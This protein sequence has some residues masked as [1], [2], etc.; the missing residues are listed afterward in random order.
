MAYKFYLPLWFGAYF[1]DLTCHTA[2]QMYQVQ[3]DIFLFLPD[4]LLLLILSVVPNPTSCPAISS[5]SD[6]L[7]STSQTSA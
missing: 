3:S 6:L 1:F 7:F 5:S 4:S 2:L